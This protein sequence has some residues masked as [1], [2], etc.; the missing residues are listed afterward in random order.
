MKNNNISSKNITIVNHSVKID[1][2][3]LLQYFYPDYIILDKPALF[4]DRPIIYTGDNKYLNQI[5]NTGV[6]YI[7]ISELAEYDL[8][9]RLTL[10]KVVFAKY[11]REVPKYLL[12][13]YED[14]DDYTFIDLVKEFWI[15]GKWNLKSYDNTGAFLEFLYSFKTDTVNI[16]KTYLQLLNKTGSEYIETSL[17]TFL[18]RVLNPS[19]NLSK[20]YQKTIDEYTASKKDLI[21]K[22]INNYVDSSITNSD[23]KIMNLILDLNRRT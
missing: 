20:W 2:L 22:A 5:R 14:L 8:T 19:A 4:I 12:E 13:F 23:L 7:L 16:T 9:D 6:N 3:G 15:T 21:E 1:D 18:N 10:L 17:L 11:H